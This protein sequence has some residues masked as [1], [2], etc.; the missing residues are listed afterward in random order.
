MRDCFINMLP[1]V[2]VGA[3]SILFLILHACGVEQKP[4]RAEAPSIFQKRPL[5]TTTGYHRSVRDGVVSFGGISLELSAEQTILNSNTV[6]D[7]LQEYWPERKSY[8]QVCFTNSNKAELGIDFSAPMESLEF[9]VISPTKR[10]ARLTESG[11]YLAGVVS[12]MPRIAAVHPGCAFVIHLC[13]SHYFQFEESGVYKIQCRQK[14][15][16]D[17]TSTGENYKWVESNWL[18]LDFP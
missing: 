4:L 15:L 10:E 5:E 17:F 16:T 8:V 12:G 18:S 6:A 7:H 11:A 1:L 13:L 14:I 9:H 2:R 3:I